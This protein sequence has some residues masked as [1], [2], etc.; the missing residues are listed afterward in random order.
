M[1]SIGEE[2]TGTP[3][4]AAFYVHT[5]KWSPGIRLGDRLTMLTWPADSEDARLNAPYRGDIVIVREGGAFYA[6]HWGY[7]AGPD[8]DVLPGAVHIAT[9]TVG[10][11]EL[12]LPAGIYDPE[13]AMR[14][15]IELT[16]RGY[17]I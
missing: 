15:A 12:W 11:S 16:Q 14:E 5:E 8:D 1:P 3:T 4:P 17:A 7:S 10:P 6:A 2:W 9:R 13:A